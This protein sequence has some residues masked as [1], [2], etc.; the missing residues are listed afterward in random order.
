MKAVDKVFQ[1]NDMRK[2]ILDYVITK[3]IPSHH[4]DTLRCSKVMKY[5]KKQ[6]EDF[7]VNYPKFEYRS[8]R[9]AV[10]FNSNTDD[11]ILEFIK[12][13]DE[14]K[15]LEK[16]VKKKYPD[17]RILVNELV[18]SKYSYSKKLDMICY[19]IQVFV[20]VYCQRDFYLVGISRLLMSEICKMNIPWGSL[21]SD[22]F[23]FKYD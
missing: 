5:Y 22:A 13:S 17:V 11:Y 8:L 15:I 16:N 7:S 20:R 18:L 3:F 9:D 23:I 1:C 12:F 2:Y 14:F 10:V 6:L 4:P 21:I 19:N